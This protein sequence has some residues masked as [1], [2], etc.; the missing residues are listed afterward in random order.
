MS[1]NCKIIRS[2]IEEQTLRDNYGQSVRIHLDQCE[3]CRQFEKEQRSLRELVGSLGTVQAPADF[4]F[5]LRAR[6]ADRSRNATGIRW[7]LNPLV[8]TAAAIVLFSGVIAGVVYVNKRSAPETL[9]SATPSPNP[10]QTPMP[11][12]T[13]DQNTALQQNDSA[14]KE[15]STQNIVRKE[16]VVKRAPDSIAQAS[17]KP[18]RPMSVSDLSSTGAQTFG[19]TTQFNSSRVFPIDA[20]LNSLKVSLDD[21]RGNARTI[22]LPGISFGSQRV[23]AT[24]SQPQQKGLW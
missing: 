6:M 5:K 22:S 15:D 12:A 19:S 21:G 8:A 14:T 16:R 3:P 18:K 10:V 9:V 2:Q 1:N 13:P 4:D 17:N 24:G 20:S 7:S 23:V 11:T